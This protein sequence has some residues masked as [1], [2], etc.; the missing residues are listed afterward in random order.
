MRWGSFKVLLIDIKMPEKCYDCPM[1]YCEREGSL[2]WCRAQLVLQEDFDE[3]FMMW[4]EVSWD[5][6]D[7]GCVLHEFP[8]GRLID[9]DA[10]IKGIEADAIWKYNAINEYDSG[11]RAGARAVMRSVRKAPTIV[12]ASEEET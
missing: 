7:S 1:C 12:P 6:I 10:L 11:I 8:H 2:A 9:A 3:P 5:K 4:K